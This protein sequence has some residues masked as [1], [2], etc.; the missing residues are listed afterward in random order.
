MHDNDTMEETQSVAPDLRGALLDIAAVAEWF[1]VT[2]RHISRLV[3]ERR[4]PFVR[5]G[6]YVRFEP[7]VLELWLDTHRVPVEH[8]SPLVRVEGR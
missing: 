3:A 6:R 7:A 4:N 2:P 5:V 1:G 8:R